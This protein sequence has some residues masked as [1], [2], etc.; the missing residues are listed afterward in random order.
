VPDKDYITAAERFKKEVDA[1]FKLWRE[2]K[3]LAVAFVLALAVASI[4]FIIGWHERG[5]KIQEQSEQIRQL[6]T[7]K[8]DLTRDLTQAR[9]ENAGLRET[10]EEINSSLKK[11]VERLESENPLEKPMAS[12]SST[13]EVIIKSDDAKNAHW[14]DQGGFLAFG[15]GDS[16]LL[17]TGGSECNVNQT[18]KGE[19]V[20]RGLFQ[21]PAD[22]SAVGKPISTL[23]ETEY[24]QVQFQQLPTDC[25][26]LSGKV[27]CVINGS[28]RLQFNVPPQH[29]SGK[30]IFIRDVQQGLLP[31]SKKT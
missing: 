23:K 12:C 7:D 30:N 4:Y 28:I 1:F 27:I 6:T 20:Y 2:R 25:E 19:I 16:A 15:R 5:S 14:I 24:L 22:D 17:S 11:I 3:W 8:S 31:L 10:G 9:T 21:M 29:S 18:G 13:I 26:V